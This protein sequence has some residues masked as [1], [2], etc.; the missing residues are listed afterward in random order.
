MCQLHRRKFKEFNSI[1]SEKWDFLHPDNQEHVL[2]YLTRLRL[3]VERMSRRGASCDWLCDYE[4]LFPFYLSI[5][6]FCV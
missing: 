4:Q 6:V 2:F 3:P 5:Q 1:K